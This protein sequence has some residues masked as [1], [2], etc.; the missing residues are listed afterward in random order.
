MRQTTQMEV[1]NQL[2]A[3]HRT[4]R[5]QAMLGRVVQLPV[6][7]YT[8]TD[9]LEC[10]MASVFRNYPMIAGHLSS[11]RDPG[12][13]LLSDWARFPYVIVRAADGRLRAFLNTC[14]HRGARIVSGKEPCLKA[15]VCPF[16]G[17]SYGLDGRLKGV[18][19]PYNFPGLDREKFALVELP[20]VER[21]GLV[22]IHPTPGATIDL[23]NDLGSIGDDLDHFA[24]NDLVSYRKNRVIKHANW[25]L[26][27][28]TY[29]EGYHV[30][31]LHRDTLS[32]A[33]K[34][35]IIAHYEHGHHIRLAAAR[36]NFLEMLPVPPQDRHIL[37]YASVYYSLFPQTFFIMHPD[38]VSINMFF[39]LAADRTMWIH[40]MLY[41]PAQFP[42]GAGQKALEKRFNYTNDAVFDQED[43][44]VAEDVQL[45][46]K[47]GANNFHTLG[48]EEGLLAIFQQGID[49]AM[50]VGAS[51]INNAP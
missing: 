37:D 9:I 20:V 28:K 7:I 8:D 22:W 1:L 21:A 15:F 6:D 40:E 14:R 4:G 11:V 44:A 32:Q 42:G 45:G 43:F 41:R 38:Y 16:H 12:A 47:H 17:W 2:E 19:K 48:L 26:L 51:K 3:L 33:F 23:D 25:K 30:P 29:L 35:G 27:I 36:T 10:E 24:L 31:Y 18:T 13:Y 50:S 5:D 46:L 39:P 49:H 34:K